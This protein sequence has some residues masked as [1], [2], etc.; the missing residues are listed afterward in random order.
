MPSTAADK[1]SARRKRAV[2]HAVL[3]AKAMT[4]ITPAVR[5]LR[6]TGGKLRRKR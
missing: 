5:L 3:A 2:S 1:P 4:G 6:L